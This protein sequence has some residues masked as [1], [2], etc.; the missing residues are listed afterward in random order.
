MSEL[1]PYYVEMQFSAV[2]MAKNKEH[3][4]KVASFLRMKICANEHME[5]SCNMELSTI[6]QM[7]GIGGQWFGCRTPYGGNNGKTLED[8]LP[9]NGL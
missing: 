2:V 5:I 7:E 1:K 3:A 6:A 8:L 9:K 4:N